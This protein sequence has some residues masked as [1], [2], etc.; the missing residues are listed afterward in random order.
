MITKIIKLDENNQYGFA[1][2]KSMPTGCIKENE[3]PSWLD[4]NILLETVDLDDPIGHLCIDDIFFDERN[5]TK[6]QWLYEETFPPIIE[7][8]KTLDVNERSA[9]QLFELFDNNKSKPKSYRDVLPNLMPL[10]FQKTLFHS[11]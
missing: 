11:I 8:Q 6:K 10:C 2:T 7:K 9:Y 3:P 5:A 4:F 1:M